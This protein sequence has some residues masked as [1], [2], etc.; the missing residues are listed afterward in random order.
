[1]RTIFILWALPVGLFWG[2]YFLS[3]NDISFGCLILSRQGHDFVFNIYGQILGMDPAVIPGFVA[4]A[5]TFDALLLSAL[6]AFRRR[7]Q[8]A[9]WWRNR[10]N[11]HARL[12]RHLAPGE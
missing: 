3:L 5:C 10:R 1:M 9:N 2:W 11:G 6:Y 12:R 8:V 7:K 4:R